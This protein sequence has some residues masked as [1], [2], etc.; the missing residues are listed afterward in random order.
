M[1]GFPSVMRFSWS[2][3]ALFLEKNA[4]NVKW[5]QGLDDVPEKKVSYVKK[6]KNEN[7]ENEDINAKPIEKFGVP[8]KKSESWITNMGMEMVSSV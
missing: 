8:K 4:Y 3:C 6:R 7:I 2:T 5:N 1:F